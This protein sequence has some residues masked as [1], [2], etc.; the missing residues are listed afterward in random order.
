MPLKYICNTLSAKIIPNCCSNALKY[1]N[2]ELYIIHGA[3]YRC[4]KTNPLITNWQVVH[5]WTKVYRIFFN[6]LLHQDNGGNQQFVNA[7]IETHHISTNLWN[8]IGVGAMATVRSSAPKQWATFQICD[9]HLHPGCPPLWSALDLCS[10]GIQRES[11]WI[12]LTTVSIAK[13]FTQIN[14][15][16]LISE[17]LRI[18]FT[19]HWKRQCQIT[20]ISPRSA[21]MSS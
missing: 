9:V 21:T 1:V 2:M 17:I 15:I 7:G 13:T 11:R 20:N 18:F 12:K 19:L 10:H 14:S 6:E 3:R 5:S 4:E 16:S 8:I